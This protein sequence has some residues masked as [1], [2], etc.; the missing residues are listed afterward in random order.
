MNRAF[1][2][3]LTLLF[4]VSCESDITIVN[5]AETR[6]V[7]DSF[8]QSDQIGELDILVALDTS[9]SMSDNFEDVGDGMDLLRTDIES[10][11]LDYQF[12]YITMDPTYLGYTGVYDS[13]S[14]AIDM[15]MAPSLLP[16]TMYEEG[17]A[18]TYTFLM[19]ADSI[20]FRRPEADFLLFLISDEDEQS[21]ITADLFY[22]WMNDEFK[23]VRHD[24][25]TVVQSEESDCPTSWD[26]GY[27]YIELSNLYGKN[28]IDIC[29]EDWSIWLSQSSFLT[30]MISSIELSETPI[31]DSIIVYIDSIVT[32]EWTYSEEANTV[33]LNSA[34]DYNSFVEVGYKVEVP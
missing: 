10:L 34:P 8:V 4:L 3:F 22:D 31:S 24:V 15:L 21:A 17:F 23:S 32:Y 11:T 27:K 20:S 5:Q 1:K 19:S 28:H 12:G 26:F 25:V 18:A 9:G 30:R 33:Y 7:V 16:A 6:V 29:E 13:S 2:L 14:T